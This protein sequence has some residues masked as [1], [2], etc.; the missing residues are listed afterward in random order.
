MF[1]QGVGA[2]FVDGHPLAKTE[3]IVLGPRS[4]T[5]IHSHGACGV[6]AISMREPCGPKSTRVSRHDG[7]A[8]GG[9]S[10]LLAYD[11][12]S[13]GELLSDANWV[14]QE[15]AIRTTRSAEPRMNRA[16]CELILARLHDVRRQSRQIR[17]VSRRRARRVI[18][19]QRA[20]D[21]IIAH[22]AEPINLSDLC[23][24]THMQPRALEYG[25]HEIV[26]LTPINYVRMLR[27]GE[28][29]RRL[30]CGVSHRRT[31][32]ELA[33]DAGFWH[34]GQ[35]AVDYKKLFMESPSV[36]RKRLTGQCREPPMRFQSQE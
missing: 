3:G 21:Y 1:D 14:I 17:G 23:G 8:L 10:R 25:F 9:G 31:I 4:K 35:F 30:L 13:V 20:R 26:G 32:S 29:H 16:C 15:L 5:E 34:F 11:R 2:V 6:V 24:R 7:A 36:T 18:G 22:L 19:V 33:L 12:N 27:L 28:V